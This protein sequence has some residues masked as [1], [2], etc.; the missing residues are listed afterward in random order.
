MISIFDNGVVQLS[1]IDLVHFKLLVNGHHL[2]IYNKL[3]S[4]RSE[5]RR[6]GKIYGIHQGHLAI[7]TYLLDPWK[8]QHIAL[9]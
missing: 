4:C 2:K 9:K 8:D 1:T 6:V 7:V 3:V 5:E